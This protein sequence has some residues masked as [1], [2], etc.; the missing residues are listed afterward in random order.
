MARDPGI[1]VG[2]AAGRPENDAFEP[3]HR[4]RSAVTVS[5]CASFSYD[6]ELLLTVLLVLMIPGLLS[7]VLPA[8]RQ[9]E[10]AGTQE[11]VPGE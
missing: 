3:R 8:R 6:V 7:Y 2:G 1:V 4:S 11:G 5:R 9:D 10:P